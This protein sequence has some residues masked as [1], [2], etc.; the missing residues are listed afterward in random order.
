[1]KMMNISAA[2]ERGRMDGPDFLKCVCICLMV[3]FHLV[4][5]EDRYPYAKDVVYTFHMPV[6]LLLSGYFARADRPLSRLLRSQ[7]R[8]FVP[9]AVMETAYVLASTVFPVRGGETELSVKGILAHV[10]L[11]PMGPYWYLHT[12][13]ICNLLYGFVRKVTL[14]FGRTDFLFLLAGVMAVACA[15]GCLS[16]MSVLYYMAGVVLSQSGVRFAALFRPSLLALPAFGMLCFF[17]DNLKAFSLGGLL[18]TYCAM[19]MILWICC[20]L[21]FAVRSVMLLVGRNTL[22]VLLFSPVFT[23]IAKHL[24]PWFRFDSSDLLLGVLAT[25]A[26]VAGSLCIA[27]VLDRL[28]LS[29]CLFGRKKLLSD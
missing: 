15:A 25:L 18:I 19:S 4:F 6:F 29:S 17:P 10:F 28:H 22:P 14:R 8:L 7:L 5:I 1:M 16:E 13:I 27:G 21:P 2:E 3:T 11:D 23:Q 26:A 12:L 9:Y 20:R 24:L